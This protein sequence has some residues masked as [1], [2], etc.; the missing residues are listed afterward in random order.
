MSAMLY[1][2]GTCATHSFKFLSPF[3]LSI[4]LSFVSKVALFYLSD[5]AITPSEFHSKTKMKQWSMLLEHT[6][7]Y[8]KGPFSMLSNF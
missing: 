6:G 1:D 4:S 2:G 8:L 3:L 7:D 5:N